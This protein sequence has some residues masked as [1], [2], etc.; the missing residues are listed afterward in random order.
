MSAVKTFNPEGHP[1]LAAEYSHVSIANLGA[2]TKLVSLA[3]QVG[4]SDETKS[5]APKFHDQVR[6]SLENVDKCL[7]AAGATKADIA[8]MRHYVVRLGSYSKED[9]QKRA[10]IV[11]EW[12]GDV[13]P[14]PNTLIGVDSL[15]WETLL[16]EIEATAVVAGGKD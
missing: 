5:V 16:I 11:S 1:S 10:E 15:A 3:G 12:W 8:S 2:G 14:A 9:M 7:A 13:T 6:I 4:W